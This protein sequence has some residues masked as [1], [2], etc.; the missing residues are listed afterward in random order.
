MVHRALLISD[1]AHDSCHPLGE[2]HRWVKT[3]GTVAAHL[4]PHPEGLSHETPFEFGL[5]YMAV[6]LVLHS[7]AERASFVYPAIEK[8]TARIPTL[9]GKDA[10]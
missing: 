6:P 2:L 3:S 4:R 9:I 7:T 5:S 10:Q 1:A 8:K